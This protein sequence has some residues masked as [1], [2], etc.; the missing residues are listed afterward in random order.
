MFSMTLYLSACGQDPW[1]TRNVAG[2]VAVRDHDFAVAES[3]FR[4]AVLEADKEGYRYPRLTESLLNLAF[5]YLQQGRLDQAEGLLR[6][7]L[8]VW[9][10]DGGNAAAKDM[11]LPMGKYRIYSVQDLWRARL[12]GANLNELL[13]EALLYQRRLSEAAQAVLESI[14]LEESVPNADPF[15]LVK[16]IRTLAQIRKL[17]GNDTEAESYYLQAEK[18]EQSIKAAQTLTEGE[19]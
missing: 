19:R 2:N 6:R 13:G 17:Q 14:R 1:V 9:E 18:R 11:F 10:E 7:A 15:K 3:E 5:V 4:E 8:K 12:Q 16:R